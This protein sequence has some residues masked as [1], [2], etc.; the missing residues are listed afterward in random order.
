M[1]VF[2]KKSTALKYVKPGHIICNDNIVKYFILQ[3]Y[4]EFQKLIESKDY[5]NFYEFIQED[6]VVNFF[7]DIEIFQSKSPEKFEKH[8]EI[9]RSIIQLLRNQLLSVGLRAVFIVV[10]SHN[11]IKKSYHIIIRLFQDNEEGSCPC[12]FRGPKHFKPVV[13]R[14]FPELVK[15][16]IIDVSVYREG[17]FRTYLSTKQGESRKLVKDALSDDFEFCES[18][19]CFCPGATEE[20]ILIPE[21]VFDVIQIGNCQQSKGEKTEEE[22]IEPKQKDLSER[23]RDVIKKFVRNNYKYHTRD[24]REIMID[25]ELNC[26]VV[27]LN[28]YYCYNIDREHKSNH[29]YIVI[30]TYSSKQKCH[31]TDC[32]DFKQSEIK[33]SCFP[34]EVNEIILKC[35]KVNKQEQELIERAIQECKDYITSNFD[36]HIEDIEFDKHTMVFKGNASNN[37]MVILNGKCTSCRVEHH[38]TNTGYCLKC[39]V[40]NSIYPKNQVI[41][42]DDRY[43]NLNTFWMNYSQLLNNGTVN[44]NIN[45]FYNGEEEFS[46]DVQLDNSI[47]GSKELTKMYNQILDG[48]KVVKISE[49]MSKLEVDFKYTSGEWYF[50]NGSIWKQDKESLEFRKT[51]LK[52]SNNFSRIQQFYETRTAGD[53]SNS[54]I[55]KNIKSLVNK[56][57]KTGFEDEIVKGAKMYYNDERFIQNLN[58]KKH[59]V[60]F[61]NG[62]YDLLENRFRKTNK[63]DYVNLTM[64]FDYDVNV[65]NKEVH[66]FIN[67]I[68]PNVSVRKYV[69]KKMSECLNGDIPNTNFMMFIGDGAN[70]KSQLL[71]LMKLTMGELGEKVEVTLLTRKR[72]NANEAN[73]EKIK[74]MHKRFAFLSEPEDGEKINIGLLKELTGSEEIVARGLYQEAV[75][76]VMEAKLFLACNDLPEIKGE[77]T[78][79]WRRIRVIDFPSRFVDEPKDDNE[80]KIDR[81]LPSR[82]REDIT[83][84]QTFI[85]MLL[86]YYYKEDITE[87]YEVKVKTNEYRQDNDVSLQFVQAYIQKEED[88]F[89]KWIDLKNAYI[90][91]F[92]ENVE[93]SHKPKTKEFK[94]YLENNL[95]KKKEM[96]IPELGRGWKGWTINQ[97]DFE[98]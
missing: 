3:N 95:F 49:L 86:N 89:V 66:S 92:L 73:S 88:G 94:R 27:A 24:I 62:V 39:S 56:L 84:R 59:L 18:F 19:V 22:R 52:L 8:D 98:L 54:N 53:T 11:D 40:C 64:S 71:N 77:D 80:F 58:S 43:K 38:I 70:G 82:M 36:E 14:L 74:L 31:D 29:Q 25:K 10:A 76:F 79:L 26:I 61:S 37:N 46:C 21:N 44:I 9:I 63:E 45:N 68:L 93:S 85:N 57:Y 7:L 78:A 65:D 15:E 30:D 2:A 5:P 42:V 6:S 33:I 83:W 96:P 12:Y 41:P 34:K 13:S 60:P 17:L 51:I 87:P 16:K 4:M 28:D 81:T 1:K 48:H 35:L 75:S 23:D 90:E 20:N 91:W 97:N 47:F 32:R 69:L 72:N 50:F 67:K 55:I